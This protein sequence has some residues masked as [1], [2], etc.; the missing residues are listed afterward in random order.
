M[1]A[2]HVKRAQ[3]GQLARTMATARA[4]GA[5]LLACKARNPVQHP[6][7]GVAK[8]SASC[9]AHHWHARP[10]AQSDHEKHLQREREG[11]AARGDGG[12]GA[13]AAVAS[14]DVAALYRRQDLSLKDGETLKCGPPRAACGRRER[15]KWRA[16]QGAAASLVLRALCGAPAYA[17]C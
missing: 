7:H 14:P 3:C 5:P 11:A 9:C 17:A 13:A 15:L 16:G 4:C 8:G 2:V 10:G 12:G 6:T 1:H